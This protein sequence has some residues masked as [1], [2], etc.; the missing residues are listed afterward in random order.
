MAVHPHLG[1]LARILCCVA[2]MVG[3]GLVV[4]EERWIGG[5]SEPKGILA[6]GDHRGPTGGL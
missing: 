3:G 2:E 1:S 6:V 4:V 5:S